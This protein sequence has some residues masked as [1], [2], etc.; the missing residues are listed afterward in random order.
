MGFL[1]VYNG[2]LL[3]YVGLT[4]EDWGESGRGVRE[5]LGRGGVGDSEFDF[6]LNVTSKKK[7]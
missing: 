3:S 6:N 1:E 5:L 4:G 2:F 7:S